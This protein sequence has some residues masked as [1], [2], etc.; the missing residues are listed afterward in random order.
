[1]LPQGRDGIAGFDPK[2]EVGRS[3]QRMTGCTG[4]DTR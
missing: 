4:Y 3:R 2:P 1:L